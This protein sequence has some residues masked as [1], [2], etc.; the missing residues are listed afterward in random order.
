MLVTYFIRA[1]AVAA[2]LLLAFLVFDPTERGRE[3]TQLSTTEAMVQPQ[4]DHLVDSPGGT[5]NQLST[6]VSKISTEK[7]SFVSAT[8]PKVPNHRIVAELPASNQS[9]TAIE[10]LEPRENVV[11]MELPIDSQL[12]PLT[13]ISP[14]AIA[15]IEMPISD[16]LKG[17]A[18]ELKAMDDHELLSR[19]K[20]AI[21]GLNLFSKLSGR[22]LTGKKGRD[23]R[24]RTISFNTQLLAFSIPLNR[25]L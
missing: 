9:M 18:K 5:S 16:F 13:V 21:V 1:T 3:V 19:N 15:N 22:N 20:V 8:A 4:S 17:R 6:P 11:T 2:I 24:L 12:V 23:G 10:V 14:Q 7:K 25:E